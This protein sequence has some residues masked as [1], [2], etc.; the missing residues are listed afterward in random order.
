[1]MKT[2][3]KAMAGLIIFAFFVKN[4]RVHA[5]DL[6]TRGASF[7]DSM[8]NTIGMVYDGKALP[9][10]PHPFEDLLKKLNRHS[11][12]FASVVPF[13]RSLQKMAAYPQSLKYPRVLIATS[14]LSKSMNTHFRGRLF[15]AYVEATRKLEVISFNPMM[16]RY[17]FQI[18]DNFYPGGKAEARY[19]PRSLCLRCH[20]GGTPIFAGGEWLETTAFNP[21]LQK[22][23]EA[24]IG[25]K[26]Y[27]GIPITRDD[28]SSKYEAIPRPE[29]FED[30]V[31]FGALLVGY[32]KA[33]QEICSLTR[34]KVQCKKKL[35]KWML[36]TNL[37]DKL[38]LE[39]DLELLRNFVSVLGSGEIDL[40]SE[41]L[42]DHNPI[43]DGKLSYHMPPEMD[44]SLPREPM[45]IIMASK[46]DPL[47][48]QFYK[49]HIFVKSMGQSFFTEKDFSHLRSLL[50]EKPDQ[51]SQEITFRKQIYVAPQTDDAISCLPNPDGLLQ[52]LNSKEDTRLPMQLS[53]FPRENWL[54]LSKAIDTL[55]LAPN[56]P[57]SRESILHELD[58]KLGT[59][60]AA[61]LCC[62]ANLDL[63]IKRNTEK[64]II[65]DP[66]SFKDQ[67]LQSFV[68]FC[69]ECH[70][71]QDLPPPF[72]AGNNEE[73]VLKNIRNRADL[74]QFRLENKQM[75]PHF[76][77]HQLSA[78]ERQ[79]L[80]QDLR[81]ISK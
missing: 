63:S 5:Q 20:Q 22:L 52:G 72:L 71:Y 28:V 33:W 9:Q 29:H 14:E 57:L 10:E 62:Q 11:S 39:P 43:V 79:D 32:Q 37:L 49:F 77:R 73:Q 48:L 81:R 69:S 27:F 35:I 54:R 31:R 74:I 2:V 44:P 53:C 16:G 51:R 25:G 13:G 58:K 1:M 80:L 70:L 34:H 47:G 15:I 26:E 17:E 67:R 12:F 64:K 61:R 30:M 24:A 19:V 4:S 65:K 76:A 36:V 46:N 41:K 42:P 68:K 8:Q 75:P 66:A 50:G 40:P 18:V 55:P 7:F 78:K 59:Q 45:Q 21:E 56:D 60:Y 6:P 23:S 3:L 38:S